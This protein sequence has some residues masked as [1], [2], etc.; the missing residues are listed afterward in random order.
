[1]LNLLPTDT[2]IIEYA[3]SGLS[4]QLVEISRCPIEPFT[5]YRLCSSIHLAHAFVVRSD[6]SMSDS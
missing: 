4:D 1:M 3:R 2:P 5:P 6:I